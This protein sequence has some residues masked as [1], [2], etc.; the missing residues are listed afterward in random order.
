MC[1]FSR[2]NVLQK[3]NIPWSTVLYFFGFGLYIMDIVTDIS[4][5]VNYIKNGQY[6]W[7]GMTMMFV[8]TGTLSTQPFSY[9]WYRDDDEE[10]KTLKAGLAVHLFGL[11]TIFRYY[12]LLKESCRVHRTTANSPTAERTGTEHNLLF[13]MA[14]DLCMLKMFEAFLESVPQI[15]LQLYIIHDQNEGFFH[16]WLSVAFSVSNV[17]Y[18]LMDF[19]V[20]LRRS[21]PHA[22]QK[23]S[24][25]SRL[26]Y[27]FYKLFTITSHILSYSLLLTLSVYSMVALTVLWLLMTLWVHFLKT[28][29]CTSKGLEFFYRLIVGFILVFTFFNVKG[30]DTGFAMTVYYMLYAIINTIAPILSIFLVPELQTRV[31]LYITCVIGG[32]TVLGFMCLILYYY[33]LHPRGMQREPDE[34]DGLDTKAKATRR[35]RRFLQP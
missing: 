12:H 33:Y 4:L 11:G 9:V 30:Q 35:I 19:R 3:M 32:T 1:A 15:L 20:C 14:T 34:V 28:D 7:G 21:L 17:A 8:V 22:R 16:Q 24:V 25:P 26:V 10:P 27:L 13:G 6:L 5:F 31:F 23:P 29:F 18:T 2:E